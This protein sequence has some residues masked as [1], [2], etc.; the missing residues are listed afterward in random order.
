MAGRG[1]RIGH[2]GA[3]MAEEGGGKRLIGGAHRCKWD[4]HGKEEACM[5]KGRVQTTVEG[6]RI[7]LIGGA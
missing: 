3:D 5:G 1:A 6:R 7:Q 2:G 4:A